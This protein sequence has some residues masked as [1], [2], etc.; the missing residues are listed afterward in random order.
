M[1]YLFVYGS[2]A[3]NRPNAHV[4]ERIGG[5]FS[6]AFIRGRLK[7]EGWGAAMGF[8]GLVLDD[9]GGRID[10]FVFCSDCLA[11]HWPELDA[12]EGD[13]YRRVK[14]RAVLTDGAGV[15]AWVY[16]LAQ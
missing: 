3:P 15:E 10:G 5:T 13:G 12:F 9:E 6:P 7:A 16:A 14:V 4:L 2:L 11:A 8:D 1:E